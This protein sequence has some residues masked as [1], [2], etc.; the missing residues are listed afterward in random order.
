M[1][2]ESCYMCD[3]L[4]VS[5]EHVPPLCIFPEK[6][7]LDDS[8][9]LRVNLIT[10]PSCDKHNSKK[11]KDD[12]LMLFVLTLSIVNN[13]T[14]KQQGITKIL[15]AVLRNPDLPK[16][17]F[18]EEVHVS[19]IDSK[20]NIMSTSMVKI[21]FQRFLRA[22]T[23]MAKA[24]YRHHFDKK[25][26]GKCSIFPDFMLQYENKEDVKSNELQYKVAQ[27]MKPVFDQEHQFGDNPKVFNY[28]LSPADSK[29]NI[30]ARMQFFEASNIY[31][32]Y[33]LEDIETL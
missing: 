15:R 7:D 13:Q 22:T 5:R 24:L 11:S 17:F 33:L 2:T 27:A 1:N 28:S 26:I 23:Q 8:E 20:E 25:F 4:A 14:A 18:S 3:E 31:I 30:G 19:A 9:N 32:A 21:D 12:E 16:Y 6:K 10:V 29:G